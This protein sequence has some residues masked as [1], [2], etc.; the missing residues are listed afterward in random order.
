MRTIPIEKNMTD[1]IIRELGPNSLFAG[2]T[3]DELQHIVTSAKMV[4]YNPGEVVMKQGTPSDNFALIVSGEV[5]VNL[6]HE[7][8][9]E[10]I[11][12]AR[13]KPFDT[14][15][16]L[17]LLLNEPRSASIVAGQDAAV[18]SF[19]K[20]FFTEMF[21][22]LPGFALVTSRVL[23]RRLQL[24]ARS[25]PISSAAPAAGKPDPAARKLLPIEFIQR[26]RVLP[27]SVKD[28]ILSIGFVE[29]PTPTV[30]TLVRELLPSMELRPVV[31]DAATFN[32]AL[33]SHVGGAAVEAQPSEG[34]DFAKS[35]VTLDHMLKRV[36][37]ERAS[38]LHLSAGHK[39]RWRIDGTVLEIAD[40]PVL[41]ATDV[42]T[43]A[44]AI[45][46]ERNRVQ[47]DADN[48]TDFA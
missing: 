36:V 33:Q 43:L 27:L 47:Y 4:Q 46:P 42:M 2:L 35:G 24:A 32:A 28:N 19:D 1:A 45:M 44:R 23:A 13:L 38:D 8:R 29:D 3:P 9:N 37:A 18:L 31:I 7:N 5:I 22:T 25:M 30:I 6:R 16:E 21:K 12:V 10:E 39:P 20:Q 17:G 15:G 40:L 48:D 14:V 26:H 41:N 11:E 34:G